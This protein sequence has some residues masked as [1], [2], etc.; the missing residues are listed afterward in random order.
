MKLNPRTTQVLKNFAS[1]NPSLQFDEGQNLKTISPN[2]TVMARAKLDDIIPQ[3]F[4]IYDLSRFLGVVSLFEDPSF[5]F[6]ASQVNISSSGRK[7]SYTYA[8]PSTIITPPN[9]DIDIGDA[10]VEVE[11]DQEVFAEIMKAMGVLGFSEVVLV[12]E[13]GKLKLRATDTK[14]PSADNFDVELGDTDLTFS[15]VFK[16]ENLKIIPANYTVRITSRGISHWTADDVEYWISI[17]S[18][19]EF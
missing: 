11:I 7:V 4:A 6:E 13:D 18:N 14:N 9:K 8:D 19:S 5:N 2:K 10:D 17:E 16:S 12:G 1:I 3:T 15:A